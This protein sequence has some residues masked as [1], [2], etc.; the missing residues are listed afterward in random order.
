[1]RLRRQARGAG[2]IEAVE[3]VLVRGWEVLQ[4]VEPDGGGALRRSVQDVDIDPD[5]HSGEA[6]LHEL[7]MRLLE[8]VLRLLAAHPGHELVNTLGERYLGLESQQPA[9]ERD[10]GVAVPDVAP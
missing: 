8:A 5:P 9:S 6:P 4:Q 10:I 3:A 2:R 7:A 1:L